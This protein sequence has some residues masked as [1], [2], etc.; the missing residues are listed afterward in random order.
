[1]GYERV[2]AKSH[3]AMLR[4]QLLDTRSRPSMGAVLLAAVSRYV[5]LLSFPR[6]L[7]CSRISDSRVFIGAAQGIPESHHRWLSDGGY[8]L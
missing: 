4:A 3:L 2:G 6:S 7:T 1:M 8:V 5:A